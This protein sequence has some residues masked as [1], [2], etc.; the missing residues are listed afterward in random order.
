L[1][2]VVGFSHSFGEELFAAK[3]KLI[4]INDDRYDYY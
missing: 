1:F 3:P 4:K 2:Y